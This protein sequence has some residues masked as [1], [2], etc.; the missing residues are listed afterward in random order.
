MAITYQEISRTPTKRG[1]WDITAE[2]T[3]SETGRK[4]TKAMYF[5]RP[6]SSAVSVTAR[7][8]AGAERLEFRVNPLNELNIDEIDIRALLTKLVVY[9]RNNPTVT[10]NE[11]VTVADTQFPDLPWKPDKI[12]SKLHV[13]L[14]ERLKVTFTWDQFKT[15]VINHKFSG[16]D[17]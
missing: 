2:F 9:I 6:E 15:Y 3:D 17:G 8:E 13:Y 5:N 10:F 12:L 4:F 1:G 16:V 11:L 14:E 7:F